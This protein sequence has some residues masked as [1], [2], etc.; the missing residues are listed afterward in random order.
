MSSSDNVD[1]DIN[2]LGDKFSKN[3]YSRYGYPGFF[4]FIGLIPNIIKGFIT[5]YEGSFISIP[6][7]IE[8]GYAASPLLTDW[9]HWIYLVTFL[10]AFQISF[11]F[12]SNLSDTFK[13]I[14]NNR[15]TNPFSLDTYNKFF[16]KYNDLAN[17]KMC[18]LC[19]IIIIELN[20]IHERIFYIHPKDLIIKMQ[21]IL[22]MNP[23]YFPLTEIFNRIYHYTYLFIIGLLIWKIIITV[24]MTHEFSKDNNILKLFKPFSPYK[25]ISLEYLGELSFKLSRLLIYF[26]LFPLIVYYNAIYLEPSVYDEWMLNGII[27]TI[28]YISMSLFL[29]FYPLFPA[30]N[31]I[32]KEKNL[33]LQNM[34][35]KLESLYSFIYSSQPDELEQNELDRFRNYRDFYSEVSKLP[36]WPFNTQLLAKFI[37]SVTFPLVLII[38]EVVLTKMIVAS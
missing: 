1:L 17:N 14:W 13:D 16:H 27:I 31:F 35:P 37:G 18:Y 20:Y 21:E 38:I 11:S 34:I 5:I 9:F 4:L 7:A 36:T 25:Y 23:L 24:K 30:H 28:I 10:L 26:G 2:F 33:L 15:N 29:F 8:E 6:I 3:F 12:L 22:W 32:K 19:G